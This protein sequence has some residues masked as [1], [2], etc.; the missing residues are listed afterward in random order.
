M[1]VHV[2]AHVQVVLDCDGGHHIR[3]YAS[4][5]T[6]PMRLRG[7]ATRMALRGMH[8][9]SLFRAGRRHRTRAP[10]LLDDG[11]EGEVERAQ[12]RRDDAARRSEMEASSTAFDDGKALDM[13]KERIELLE[14]KETQMGEIK[15]M[16]ASS[17]AV[18][19]AT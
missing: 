15:D 6:D 18:D 4:A 2:R 11:T 3:Q 13:L 17:A 8:G 10:L 19:V 14:T 1:H 5:T 7:G 9:S 16:C 12:R